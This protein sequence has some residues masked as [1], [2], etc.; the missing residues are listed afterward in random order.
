MS[1]VVQI[2][3][4]FVDCLNELDDEQ[5][6]PSISQIDKSCIRTA[7]HGQGFVD[8]N[9]AALFGSRTL[10]SSLPSWL[11]LANGPEGSLNVSTD[12]PSKRQGGEIGN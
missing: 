1:S 12:S 4:E 8:T 3:I 9:S 5:I 7:L 10:L 6:V 11:R 2:W